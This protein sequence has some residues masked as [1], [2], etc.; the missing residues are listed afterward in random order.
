MEVVGGDGGPGSELHGMINA[1]EPMHVGVRHR[2][3]SRTIAE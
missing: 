1:T 3:E 2:E